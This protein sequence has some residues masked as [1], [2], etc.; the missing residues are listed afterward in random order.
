VDLRAFGFLAVI[1]IIIDRQPGRLPCHGY[2]PSRSLGLVSSATSYHRSEMP[3]LSQ[4]YLA[5]PQ[6]AFGGFLGLWLFR[7]LIRRDLA[8][9]FLKPLFVFVAAE[10]AGGFD[11]AIELRVCFT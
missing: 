9:R 3:R 4:S 6:N 7:R 11:K 8:K 10:L 2:V 1:S 5:S